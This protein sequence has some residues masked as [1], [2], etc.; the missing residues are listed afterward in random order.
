MSAARE[1]FEAQLARPDAD[2]TVSEL[3]ASLSRAKLEALQQVEGLDEAGMKLVMPSLYEQIVVTEIQMAAHVGLAVGLALSIYDE[4]V[5]GGSISRFN[6]QVREAMTET[7]VALK[8]RQ[9]SR[10]AKLVA[11]VEAQRLA[12]RHSHEFLSW[13]AFRRGDDKYPAAD[14]LERLEAFKVSQRLL[15]SRDVLSK[16]LG[17]RLASAVEGHDRYML[18]NRWPL[19]ASP[20]EVLEVHAWTLL[21]MQPSETVFLERKRWQADAAKAGG[22]SPARAGELE[23]E[24][25]ELLRAQLAGALVDL[26]EKATSGMF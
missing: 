15:Q 25:A 19:Q 20:E 9:S 14:R 8:R 22:A 16:L 18:A 12:W 23:H 13:L 7:A 5:R 10:L 17:V 24:V 4:H 26:P 2:P 21:S 1:A 6:R 11:E 3:R